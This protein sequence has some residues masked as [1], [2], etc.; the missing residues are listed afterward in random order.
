MPGRLAALRRRAPGPDRLADKTHPPA[1]VLVGER[2]HLRNDPRRVAAELGHVREGQLAGHG[3]QAGADQV[4]LLA[5]QRDQ[6]GLALRQ[7]RLDEGADRAGVVGLAAVEQWRVA[8]DAPH[9]LIP[10]MPLRAT[11]LATAFS[12]E[13]PDTPGYGSY[14]LAVALGPACGTHTATRQAAKLPV[15]DHG[16]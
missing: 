7:A 3:I 10:H 12:H 1:Q 14:S 6:R 11:F 8:Q 2:A 9:R 5:G 16:G 15:R 13:A 4:A